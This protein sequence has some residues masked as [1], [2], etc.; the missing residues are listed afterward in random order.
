MTFDEIFKEYYAL[1]RGQAVKTPVFGDREYMT[2]I[3]LANAAIRKWER[4]DGE[5]WRELFTVA[6]A[7][8]D[9]E[10]RMV[11]GTVTYEA[12]KDMRKT[13]GFI[14]VGNSIVKTVH[15]AE[16]DKYTGLEGRLVWFTGSAQ[17]GYL[18]NITPGMAR[19]F[20][21]TAFTYTYYKK[22]TLL[23][24]DTDPGDIV[25]EMSDPTFIIQD[26]L[27]TRAQ[28]ARNGFVFKAAKNESTQAL[29]NMKIEN[30]SGT[31]GNNQNLTDRGAG[32][33]APS[34]GAATDIRL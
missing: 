5:L 19:D 22:A 10:M 23:P 14:Q 16:S 6:D 31:W 29:A 26:M 15:P 18:M 2:A 30:S 25:P 1:Y 34:F 33:G 28:Q 7:N 32:W 21:G 8:S 13:P 3:Q 17:G 12:P 9:G 20:S 24:F 27:A 4:A 11:D